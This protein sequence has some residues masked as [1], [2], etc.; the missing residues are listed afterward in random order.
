MPPLSILFAQI[1]NK[2]A[3]NLLE[4]DEK[5]DLASCGKAVFLLDNMLKCEQNRVF[6]RSSLN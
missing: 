1:F 2:D 3:S 6:G 5:D 4:N